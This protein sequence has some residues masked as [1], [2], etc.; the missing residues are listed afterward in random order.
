MIIRKME[1]NEIDSIITLF[2]YY[3]DAAEIPEEKYDENK[4]I[5][6][7]REYNIRPN[8]FFR[9]AYNGLRPVG[10]IGG[11]L[12]EDP[13]DTELIATI[14]FNFLIDEYATVEGYREL[15]DA[16]QEWAKELKATNI[17]AIDIGEKVSR[18]KQVY[19]E[20]GFDPVRVEIMNKE[21]Q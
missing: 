21:I 17:R 2:N 16:F 4:V 9:V 19:Y 10:F 6:T 1:T 20:L 3:R 8:L 18:L 14:Q 5:N 13:V 12:S 7:V 15:T 11:F